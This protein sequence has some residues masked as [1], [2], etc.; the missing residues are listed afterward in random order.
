MI[1]EPNL[2]RRTVIVE[3]PVPQRNDL[4]CQVVYNKDPRNQA[5]EFITTP[6]VTLQPCG[7]SIPAT[8]PKVTATVNTTE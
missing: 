3:Y 6:P 7:L 5:H 4:V 2:R 1:S 8:H